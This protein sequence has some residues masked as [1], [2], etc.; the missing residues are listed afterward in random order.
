MTAIVRRASQRFLRS[1]WRAMHELANRLPD[2][3][4]ANSIGTRLELAAA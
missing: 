1:G 2:A 3:F 4:I